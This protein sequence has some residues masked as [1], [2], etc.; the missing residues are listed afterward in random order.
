[1]SVYRLRGGQHGYRGNVIN[2]PQ[3]VQE[4]VTHLPRHPTLLDVLVI[5]RQFASNLAA[6]TA[7]R[8]FNVRRTKVARALLW[9]KK[10][11]RYYSDIIINNEVLQSL[12]VDGP[13]DDQLRKSQMN[14]EEFDDEG[15]EDSVITR[16]FVPILP[17]ARSENVAIKNT[18]NHVQNEI[19]PIIWSQ[20][21]SH[22]VNEFQTPGYIACAFPAL[23]PTGSADL[24]AE[25]I[26]EVKL[27]EYFKHLL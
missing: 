22:P 27:A 20:I 21:D 25:R 18:L 4:F 23:Y 8:Q 6:S 14:A 17:L 11:N 1:M 7:F 2:F 24:R 3:N 15:N 12:P 13:I 9:L 19:D 26:K 16:T 5:C 10:N